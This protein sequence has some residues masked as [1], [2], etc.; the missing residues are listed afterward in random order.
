MA[1]QRRYGGYEIQVADLDSAKAWYRHNLFSSSTNS[2]FGAHPVGDLSHFGPTGFVTVLPTG[3]AR[4]RI[5]ASK[6]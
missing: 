4:K 6:E 2:F 3:A 1:A 5:W